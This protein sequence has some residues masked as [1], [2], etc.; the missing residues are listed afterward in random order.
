MARK[1]CSVYVDPAALSAYVAGR[2]IAIDKNPG[3]RPIGVGEVC[4]WIISKAILRVVGLDIQESSGSSQ[5]CDGQH[6]G[7]ETT[8]DAVRRLFADDVNHGVLLVDA[9]NAF[10]SLNRMVALH[11][12]S[13]LCPS[14]ARV[15][16]N[17]YRDPVSMFIG[18]DCILV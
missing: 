8:I 2:L 12:I 15:L 14:F 11:N 7:C 17:T 13:Q 4:R 10:N 1:L 5:L 6:G 18:N 16:I 9:C 3:V